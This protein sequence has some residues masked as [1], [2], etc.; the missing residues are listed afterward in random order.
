MMVDGKIYFPTTIY[1]TN[2]PQSKIFIIPLHQSWF[3]SLDIFF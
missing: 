3:Q 2:Y 1:K